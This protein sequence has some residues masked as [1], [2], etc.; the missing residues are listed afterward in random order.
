MARTYVSYD[1]EPA[2]V[3]VQKRDTILDFPTGF[4]FCVSN[5]PWL[6]KNSAKRRGLTFP[7]T[8]F[9]DLYKYALS[10]C[11]RHSPYVAVLIPAT[12]LRSKL[13]RERL[14]KVVFLHGQQMFMDTENP[15]CL[16]LFSPSPERVH[17]F[18]DEKSIGYLNELEKHLPQTGG[19]TNIVFN[20]PKGELGFIAFDGTSEETIRFIPGTQLDDYEVKFTSRMITRIRAD[21]NNLDEAVNKLNSD[22]RSFRAATSDVFLTPFKGLRKDGKYR[23]RMDYGLARDFILQYA[24]RTSKLRI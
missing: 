10:L 6:A 20:H 11:L 24:E 5:P 3:N 19:R 15:V 12:F 13:F 22:I 14:E 8:T 18:N 16:A 7:E 17:V 9:D 21:L 1:I 23:R 4:S 2:D